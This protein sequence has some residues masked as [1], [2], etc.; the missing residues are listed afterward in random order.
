L[1]HDA[2]EA[3]TS[4][5]IR[6]VLSGGW[7]IPAVW[8]LTP[9]GGDHMD[10]RQ[11]EQ[12][13]SACDAI[14]DSDTEGAIGAIIVWPDASKASGVGTIVLGE[15]NGQ[16]RQG[17]AHYVFAENE[18]DARHILAVMNAAAPWPLI[19]LAH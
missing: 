9:E 17:E 13:L 10:A 3:M 16:L 18:D 8:D 2:I 15:G 12:L 4:Y 1:S 14:L 6:L 7:Q 11:N 19:L 5:H